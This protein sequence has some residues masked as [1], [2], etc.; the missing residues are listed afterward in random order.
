M[1]GNATRR[2]HVKQEDG[3]VLIAQ[4]QAAKFMV[5]ECQNAGPGPVLARLEAT[6][7]P[8]DNDSIDGFELGVGDWFSDLNLDDTVGAGVGVYVRGNAEWMVYT[9][10]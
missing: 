10:P 6:N 5:V 8:P 9:K 7:D 1:A 2:L 4:K 3:W